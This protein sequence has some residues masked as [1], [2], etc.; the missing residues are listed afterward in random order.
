MPNQIKIGIVGPCAAGKSTLA[1]GLRSIGITAKHIAQEHSY[2]QNMWERITNPDILISLSVS[3]LT[4]L[5]RRQLNWSLEEFNEQI[6]RLNHARAHAD[7]VI[8]TD[9]YTASEVLEKVRRYL[10]V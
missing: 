10:E 9:Q 8:D 5:H 1:A 3:Y 2:V 6:R 7:L 4:T